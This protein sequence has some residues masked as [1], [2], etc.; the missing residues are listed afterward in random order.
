MTWISPAISIAAVVVVLVSPAVAAD[1]VLNCY[2]IRKS[3]GFIDELQFQCLSRCQLLWNIA[4]LKVKRTTSS[5]FTLLK[6]SGLRKGT[7]RFSVLAAKIGSGEPT[8]KLTTQVG[9]GSKG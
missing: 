4:K 2:D 8:V 5:T 7:L 1:C 6:V 3:A 9:H